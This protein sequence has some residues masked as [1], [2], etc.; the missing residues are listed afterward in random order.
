MPKDPERF[1]PVVSGSPLDTLIR[2]HRGEFNTNQTVSFIR[3][4]LMNCGCYYTAHDGRPAYRQVDV[5]D[6]LARAERLGAAPPAP[7]A[8]KEKS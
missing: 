2:T 5:D 1:E 4:E 8:E 3:R 7:R 6:I